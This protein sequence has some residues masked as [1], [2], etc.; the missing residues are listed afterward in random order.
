L[1]GLSAL[2]RAIRLG[3][4]ADPCTKALSP[5]KAL[6]LLPF[7]FSFN[8]LVFKDQFRLYNRFEPVTRDLL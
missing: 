8:L 1:V 6:L 7:F 3:C 4:Y 2:A 5:G